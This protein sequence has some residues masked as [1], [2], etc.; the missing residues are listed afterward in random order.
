MRWPTQYISRRLLCVSSEVDSDLKDMY[1]GYAV[2]T[3]AVAVRIA[4]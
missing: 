1:A 3:T 4:D 2:A